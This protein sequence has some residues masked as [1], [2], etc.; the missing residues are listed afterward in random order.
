ME[1]FGKAKR[2]SLGRHGMRPVVVDGERTVDVEAR[3]VVGGK[4]DVPVPAAGNE[5]PPLENSAET[6]QEISGRRTP[7]AVGRGLVYGRHDANVQR[8]RKG[9]VG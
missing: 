1:A 4:F 3:A 2:R 7:R 9:E 8:L 6:I 5:Q